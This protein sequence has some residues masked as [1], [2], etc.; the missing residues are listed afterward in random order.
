MQTESKRAKKRN[1]KYGDD[2]VDGSNLED[3]DNF[4]CPP[5]FKKKKAETVDNA[6]LMDKLYDKL[7]M[8]KKLQI[9]FQI[10]Y[11]KDSN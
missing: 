6:E 9:N 5:S 3:I 2:Y 10:F 11:T 4:I 1:A 8:C 7:G